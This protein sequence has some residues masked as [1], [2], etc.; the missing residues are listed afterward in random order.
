MTL[1]KKEREKKIVISEIVAEKKV[2]ESDPRKD[3]VANSHIMGGSTISQWIDPTV[4]DGKGE[5]ITHE[6]LM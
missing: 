5:W 1:D 2:V 3:E 6:N 4:D